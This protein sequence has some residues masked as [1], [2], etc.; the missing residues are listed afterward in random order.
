MQ[1]L[2]LDPRNVATFLAAVVCALASQNLALPAWL[3]WVSWNIMAGSCVRHFARWL[4]NSS[5][6]P[7]V[8]YAAVFCYAMRDW[9]QMP[10]FL[11]LDTTMLFDRFCCVRISMIYLNRAI[12]IAW[13]VLEHRSSTV[14]Y[15]Q[16]SYLLDRVN[17]MLPSD[18]EIFFL[19]DRG[20]VS[21][22]LMHHLQ[23]LHWHWRIRVR[24]NQRLSSK[25]RIII[26]KTLPLSL[27]KVLLFSKS[28]NFGKGLDR[29]SLSAGWP[30]GSREPW[31]VLSADKACLEVFIDYGRRFGIEEGFKDEKSGG[32]DLEESCIR[33]AQKLERLILVVAVALIVAVSEG[34]SVVLEA[35][36]EEV[37]PHWKQGLSYFQI[38]LRWILK[39]IVQGL[40]NFLKYFSL[41]PI[42]NPLPIAPTEKESR[43]RRKMKDPKHLFWD[44]QHCESLP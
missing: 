23:E 21:K 43:R 34:V 42:N 9:T 29:L 15:E 12:P 27:G 38:G 3:P 10:I 11:A 18:V 14:K 36:R 28:I 16:Y 32:F 26:P 31:Y 40:K 2:S 19:A 5:I 37:D 41:R 7:H 35:R 39:A 25:G 22:K 20:F 24:G 13:C 6:L 33:D 4:G 17:K 30:K 44:V 8:W 1:Q